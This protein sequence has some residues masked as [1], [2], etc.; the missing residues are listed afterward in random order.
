MTTES[1]IGVIHW[2]IF[3][4]VGISGSENLSIINGLVNT[5][6]KKGISESDNVQ[7]DRNTENLL[8]RFS[9]LSYF[10]T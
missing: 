4:F 3:P 2:F 10:R 5:A 6:P 1:F 7:K 9:V 8:D